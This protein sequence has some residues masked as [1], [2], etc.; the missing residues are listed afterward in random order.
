MKKI[1]LSL[2]LLSLI[3]VGLHAEKKESKYYIDTRYIKPIAKIIAGTAG[4]IC[5]VII[6]GMEEDTKNPLDCFS[7]LWKNFIVED[8]EYKL[9]KAVLAFT[10][11]AVS[12]WMAADGIKEVVELRKKSSHH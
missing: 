7:N 10:P 11:T 9:P 1:M 8:K 2:A 6:A 3:P 5:S 4:A 12:I